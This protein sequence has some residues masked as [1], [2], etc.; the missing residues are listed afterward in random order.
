[1]GKLADLTARLKQLTPDRMEKLSL[2][3][4]ESHATDFIRLNEEQ[5]F[6]GKTSDN[7]LIKPPYASDAYANFKLKHNPLGVVDLFLTGAFYGSFFLYTT[8]YPVFI[9]AT[10][11]KTSKLVDQ[12]G[13]NIFG[14]TKENLSIVA[15]AI[16]PDYATLIRNFIRL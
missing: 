8:T 2:Q 7:T 4:I 14:L 6:E 10:D 16:L 11:E 12:Y 3:V 5:L 9:F 13:K 1:M 15:K